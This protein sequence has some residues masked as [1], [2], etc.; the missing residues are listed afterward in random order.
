[1]L[2]I[3]GGVTTSTLIGEGAIAG[4]LQYMAPEQID[5]K[6]VDERC[7]IFA[8]GVILYE[9]LAGRPAFAGD[10]PSSLMAAILTSQPVPLRSLQP[11]VSAALTKVVTKC[12]AKRPADR[13]PSADAV[14]A[15][16][17][18]LRKT[19]SR[20]EPRHGTPREPADTPRLRRASDSAAPTSTPPLEQSDPASK[21]RLI[22]EGDG[23]DVRKRDARRVWTG[24][25]AVVLLFLGAMTALFVARFNGTRNATP[26]TMVNASPRRTIAV[27]GFRNLAG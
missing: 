23:V 1:G 13:W 15:A 12:L 5:G 8:L 26:A 11:E 25:L 4:T 18:K 19:R 24:T 3:V 14:A 7:D 20:G 9:M 16:L 6:P 17:R 21:V 2:E 27:L 22:P 10:V